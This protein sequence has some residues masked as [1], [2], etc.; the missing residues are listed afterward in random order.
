MVRFALELALAP[1]L[2]AAST[3]ACQRWSARIG[4]LL[5][6]FPAVV[7]PLLLITAQERGAAF[8]T[9]TATA[10][11]LGL[12]TLA[13]FA[14]VYARAAAAGAGWAVS[15]LA[16]WSC[17]AVLGGL[18]QLISVHAALPIGLITATLALVSAHRALPALPGEWN[19][20]D[21]SG[22]EILLRMAATTGLVIGLALAAQF[23]GPRAG[24]M[25]AGLPALASV[26]AV[27]THR[28]D[29]VPALV[30][31]MR[32]LLAGM[33]GFVGFCSVVALLIAPAGTLFAFAVATLVAVA[34][35]ALA[36]VAGK[37]D[38]S[39]ADALL[40]QRGV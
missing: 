21:S 29:G 9:S 1:S 3:L 40:V 24:G 39:R 10:T 13:G 35:E 19:S 38:L 12:I 11:L 23:L 4:G 2:V 30:A 15:L 32:G 28:R 20:T 37:Q 36:Y 8:A 26:L 6:A 16:G 22:R 7:G 25:L 18:V 31:L 5:S 17:A 34:L 33:A 14:L 27:F